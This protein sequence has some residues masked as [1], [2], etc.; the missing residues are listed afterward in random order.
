MW[1]RL[2]DEQIEKVCRDL[3]GAQ[4]RVGV[5]DVM[6][7]LRAK[8]GSV[9]RTER[10]AGLLSRLQAECAVPNSVPSSDEFLKLRDRLG[11]VEVRAERA[12]ARAALAEEREIKHQNYWAGR[13]G[14]RLDELEQLHSA[15]LRAAGK[16]A[17]E[18]YLRLYQKAA[19]LAE[20]LARY[21]EVVPL[22]PVP[23]GLGHEQD[24]NADR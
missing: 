1:P 5:R 22:S 9:G 16:L 13:Y 14:A 10:V 19:Q 2:S 24:P 15:Q 6:R 11:A 20:R 23:E 18:R 21:E 3:L 12:E 8:F 17:S 4:R 7:R